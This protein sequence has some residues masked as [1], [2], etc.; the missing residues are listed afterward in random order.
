MKPSNR[1][2]SSSSL[3]G[4]PP[5]R[6][7]QAPAST[8]SAPSAADKSQRLLSKKESGVKFITDMTLGKPSPYNLPLMFKDLYKSENICGTHSKKPLIPFAKLENIVIFA[9]IWLKKR[10]FCRVTQF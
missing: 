9:G 3:A 4:S 1:D 7:E 2:N 5:G 8:M 6:V 10:F